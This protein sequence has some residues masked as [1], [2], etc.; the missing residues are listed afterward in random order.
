[1]V[2]VM[3]RKASA[4]WAKASPNPLPLTQEAMEIAAA[5]LRSARLLVPL[6]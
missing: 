3:G 1:M 5:D 6:P 2:V 4:G